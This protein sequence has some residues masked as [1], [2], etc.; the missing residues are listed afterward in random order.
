MMS[1]R[2]GLVTGAAERLTGCLLLTMT[3][4]TMAPH[5]RPGQAFLVDEAAR[6]DGPGLYLVDEGGGPVVRRVEGGG[7]PGSV[8]VS[9]SKPGLSA[10]TAAV[11]FLRSRVRGRVV[12]VICEV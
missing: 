6:L 12:G 10:Y 9:Y 3:G 8:A 2:G 4:D 7:V 1:G 5:I 11:G